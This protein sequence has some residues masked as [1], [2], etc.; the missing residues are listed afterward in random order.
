MAIKQEYK[1]VILENVTLQWVFL[2]SPSSTGHYTVDICNL[3]KKN[4]ETLKEYGIYPKKDTPE[5]IEKSGFDR[6]YYVSSKNKATEKNEGNKFLKIIDMEGNVVD[7]LLAGG[8]VAHVKCAVYETE[9]NKKKFK[10][11][12]VD[13]IKVIKLVEFKGKTEDPFAN[14]ETISVNDDDEVPF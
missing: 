4:I 11:L 14:C 9:F 12:R 13:M 2:R 7:K 10:K 6:G 5:K 1:S 8:T 3:S